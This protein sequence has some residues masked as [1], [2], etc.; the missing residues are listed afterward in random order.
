MRA[1]TAC[2]V[3]PSTT[4]V[5]GGHR[6]PESL[7]AVRKRYKR[8]SRFGPGA[9]PNS[10][11]TADGERRS[12]WSSTGA[13]RDWFRR[14]HVPSLTFHSQNADGGGSHA[15][16]CDCQS[17][18]RPRDSVFSIDNAG[19]PPV[20]TTRVTMRLIFLCREQPWEDHSGAQMR[21]YRLIAGLARE[22]RVTLVT[23]SK[24][25]V[26][27][28]SRFDELSRSCDDIIEVPL[29][30][31]NF[32]RTRRYEDWA[33]AG[34]RLTTLLS[35]REPRHVRRWRSSALVETLR[36]IRANG[37]FDVVVASRPPLAEMARDAG[38]QRI[39]LDLPDL[40]SAV[41]Q[42]D[43]SLSP[44]YKSKPIDWAE[45]AKFRAYDAR[46]P[47]RFWRVAVC[48]EE[49]RRSFGRGHADNVV[50]IPNGTELYPPSPHDDE[51]RNELLFVGKL[52]YSP[53]ADAVRFF[54]REILPII[55][56][57][58]PDAR[59]RIIGFAPDASITQLDNGRDCVVNASVEDLTPYYTG[60]SVAVVPMR[61]G[62][63]TK[64]KVIEALARGKALVSTSFG[65]EGFDLRPGVDLDI[66]DTPED[67]AAH[68]VRLL[69]DPQARA[70]LAAN[71]RARVA[72][73]YTWDAITPLAL[74]AVRGE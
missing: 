45:A 16:S 40:E 43:L 65:A 15:F 56:R 12:I 6:V 8:L 9:R 5:C 18:E 41:M 39:L 19:R 13:A 32:V 36:R 27:R 71:G 35:S 48:K 70:T 23:F 54:H 22:H 62:G 37:G 51:G 73:R 10:T 46:L 55:R 52:S 17:S 44:G 7:P 66:G 63:G 31:C 68:C 25:N 67:F 74:D 30:T 64:L 21:N 33:G 60:A 4:L 59:F 1:E 72:E 24:P 49:D 47:A 69:R 53:N 11:R 14:R 50:L 2:A 61:L 42:R 3:N 38:F 29:A 34:T 26:G 28:N 58:I 57:S 20:S